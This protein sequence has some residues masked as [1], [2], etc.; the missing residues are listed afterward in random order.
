MVVS[1]VYFKIKLNIIFI[2]NYKK[3]KKQ[4]PHDWK[5]VIIC[6]I[7]KKGDT[8]DTKNYRGIALLNTCYKILS[9]PILHRLK[10]Y[11]RHNRKI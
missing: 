11:S 5:T 7:Y 2:Y 4:I 10:I 3:K 1:I 8:M 9:T 6:P